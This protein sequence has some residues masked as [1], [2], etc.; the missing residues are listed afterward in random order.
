[1]CIRDSDTIVLEKEENKDFKILIITDLQFNDALDLC[2]KA[3]NVY[4]TVD[5]PVSYT[6]LD[7]YKRQSVTL[8]L[9]ESSALQYAFLFLYD[10]CNLLLS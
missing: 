3:D 6:H 2:G 4:E 5:T 9:S 8:I 7:V 1:M 10:V